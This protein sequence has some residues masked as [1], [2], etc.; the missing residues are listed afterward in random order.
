MVEKDPAVGGAGR[1]LVRQNRF[2]RRLISALIA[3]AY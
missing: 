2:I 3:V 1:F